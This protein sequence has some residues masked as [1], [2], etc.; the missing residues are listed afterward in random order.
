MDQVIHQLGPL[1]KW[2]QGVHLSASLSGALVR[3]HLAQQG[4]APNFET[5]GLETLEAFQTH[6]F[7][8]GSWVRRIDQHRPFE[9]PAIVPWIQKLNPRYLVHEL[10]VDQLCDLPSLLK[11][12]RNLFASSSQS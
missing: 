11:A 7:N 3:T 6:C 10:L 1:K 8:S 5:L 2:I 9:D 4:P 12:Q